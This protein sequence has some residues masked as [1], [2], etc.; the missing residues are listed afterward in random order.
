MVKKTSGLRN[1]RNTMNRGSTKIPHLKSKIPNFI[2]G[3]WQRSRFV[4]VILFASLLLS[5]CV[6]YDL[7]VNFDSPNHGTIVQHI[8]LGERLV[9]FSGEEASEWLNSIERR[10]RKLQGKT[11]RMSSEEIAVRIPFNNGKELQVKF[12]EFFQPTATKKG[13][14]KNAEAES[15]LPKIESNLIVNQ[16]NFLLMERNRLIYDLDLRSLSLIATDNNVLVNPGSVLDL[17]FTLNT[18]WGA[19]LV[20]EESETVLQAESRNDGKQLVWQ[21]I[22]GQLNHIDV[23]F[24]LPSPI[25]IGAVVIILFVTLGTYLRYSFMPDPTIKL[26]PT[27][28]S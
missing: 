27:E 15:E 10:A 9:S 16:N 12:N 13:Q 8:K 7:G 18:P 25:G 3:I 20:E 22:P 14:G 17:E 11:L 19:K 23:V 4:W 1:S 28:Q 2:R 5:G 26:A 6:N 21:L 24:W